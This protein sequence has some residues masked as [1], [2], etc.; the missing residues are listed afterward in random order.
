M[1]GYKPTGNARPGGPRIMG[2]PS[3]AP[4]RPALPANASPVARRAVN[5]PKRRGGN[6]LAGLRAAAG[7]DNK[8]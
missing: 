5:K 7:F 8:R 1:I 6:V 3:S 4:A 2:E